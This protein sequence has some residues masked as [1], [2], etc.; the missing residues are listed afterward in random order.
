MRSGKTASPD[1]RTALGSQLRSLSA[2]F[3]EGELAYLASTRKVEDSVRDKI[4]W[5]LHRE[6]DGQGV[7]VSR[8]WPL[9]GGKRAD[10]ALLRDSAVWAIVEFK[11]L[12]A[13]DVHIE[14]NRGE[15]RERVRADLAR[16]AEWEPRAEAY[17]IVLTT[18]I[19]GTI[20]KDLSRVVKYATGVGRAL[21]QI[22]TA[23]A[24]RSQAVDIWGEDLETLGAPVEAFALDSGTVWGLSIVLDAWLV[25]PVPH[26]ELGRADR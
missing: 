7:V 1:L 9:G 14:K 23:D 20:G 26:A 3:E 24:V 13:F 25:G 2:S 8:E 12:Y 18:H 15:Y 17:A 11:A 21:A 5:R 16:A 10:L 4:A 22:G 19:A 6:L